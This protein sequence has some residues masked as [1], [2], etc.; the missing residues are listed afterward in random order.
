MDLSD[1]LSLDL[2]RLCRA[3]KL[4][5]AIAAPPLYP[6]ATLEQA[7][8]GGEDYELLFTAPAGARVPVEFEGVPL[9]RIGVMRRGRPGE[10]RLDGALLPVMGYDHF[11][12]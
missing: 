10:V 2:W 9:T 6:G 7:L 12:R 11:R 8:H 1:G 4:S 5:A 3:S